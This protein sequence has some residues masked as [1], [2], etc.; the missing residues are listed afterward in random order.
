M[1]L[2]KIPL[3][4]V[5]LDSQD[6][7][8]F[9]EWFSDAL[10]KTQYDT[11]NL[12]D[13]YDCLRCPSDLLW[14]L[15]D[16][17]GYKL[18]SRLPIAFNRL[19]LLYFMSMIRYKGSKDGVTLAAQVN[20]AQNSIKEYGK[21][22]DILYDRLEDTSIPVNSVYV[23]PNTNKGYIDVVYYST[24]IP[25]DAC[26]EYV[27]PLGM[28]VFQHAGVSVNAKSKITVDARLTN[29]EDVGLSI[30]PTHVGHYSR[31]DYARMQRTT[32]EGKIDEEHTRRDVWYRNSKYEGSAEGTE[33]QAKDNYKGKHIN[34]GYRSLYSLQLCNNDHV[35]K[36]N[37][38]PIFDIKHD[39][40]EWGPDDVTTTK[41]WNLLYNSNNEPTENGLGLGDETVVH[42]VNPTLQTIGD[43]IWVGDK[44]THVKDN[45]DIELVDPNSETIS[46]PQK[47]IND[48]DKSNI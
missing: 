8:F 21:Q 6:F 42:H 23:S 38:K 14:M 11:E 9:I 39:I 12:S 27:R 2:K 43:A 36:S 3:P 16:T 19:V 13:I 35:I 1:D 33:V 24:E 20:L 31:E 26:I 15:A 5:Y 47:E 40:S 17:M 30:G 28:Y 7:R 10:L 46:N 41:P 45:G 44:Y 18:D 37:L 22:N 29:I 4:E 34:P 48:T 32:D 25:I